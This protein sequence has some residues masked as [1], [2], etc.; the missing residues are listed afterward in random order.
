MQE[1]AR[2]EVI[3]NQINGAYVSGACEGVKDETAEDG[4]LAALIKQV[5]EARERLCDR[6]KLNSGSDP[7]IEDIFSG[8]EDFSRA[9]GKLM[10]QYGRLD[11]QAGE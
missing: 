10:Y 9:C 3:Y 1:V 5:Y 7:D 11:G 2:W 8:F 4:V 6:A